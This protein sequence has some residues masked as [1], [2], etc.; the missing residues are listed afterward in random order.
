[1]NIVSIIQKS[2]KTCYLVCYDIEVPDLY[3]LILKYRGY[4]RAM[5]HWD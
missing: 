3:S 1:M 2:Y 4:N 5:G